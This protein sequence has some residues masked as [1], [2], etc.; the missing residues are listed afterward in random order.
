[1][2]MSVK[3]WFILFSKDR[4]V[5]D[6]NGPYISTSQTKIR[7]FFLPVISELCLSTVYIYQKLD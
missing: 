4:K 5:I 1:M 3:F 2:I 7:N 6:P